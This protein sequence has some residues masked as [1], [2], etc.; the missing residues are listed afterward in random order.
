MRKK[1]KIELMYGGVGKICEVTGLNRKTVSVLTNHPRQTP[2][3]IKIM[4]A[5]KEFN[6]IRRF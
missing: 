5:A 6:L 1:N 4:K 2:A 3:F